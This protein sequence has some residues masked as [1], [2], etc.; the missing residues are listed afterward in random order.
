MRGN[1]CDNPIA[2]QIDDNA[3]NL[4][5]GQDLTEMQVDYICNSIIKHI[6]M[7]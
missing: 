4:P 1:E 3:M 6:G 2:Q 7:L 5:S